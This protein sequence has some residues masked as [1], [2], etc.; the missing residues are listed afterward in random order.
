MRALRIATVVIL[1]SVFS[2]S[3]Q[4]ALACACGCGV[5]EVGGAGV[6]PSGQG[7]TAYLEFDYADQNRNWHGDSR[8]PAADND[9]KAVR[10]AFYTAGL[11]YMFNREWGMEVRV[12]YIYRAF[13][14]TDDATGDIVTNRHGAVGDIR[15]TGIYTGFSPDMSTGIMFGVKLPTGD[16]HFDGF[17]RDTA[18]GTGSTD[19]LLGFYHQDR[20]T[21]DNVYTWFAEAMWDQ[22]ILTHGDYRPGTEINASLGAYHKPLPLAGKLKITPVLQLI[23]TTRMRD[24][25]AEAMRDDSGYNRLAIA[26]AVELSYGNA[27]LY[28]DVEVPVWQQFNGNQLTAP[29]LF[30]VIASYEF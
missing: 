4:S 2:F 12:P 20:I 11:Q 7:G 10:N 14:T 30:K 5:F 15:L 6:M 13:T 21:K 3:S 28:G 24:T 16:Y 23:G 19:S 27:K 8:A 18:I 29:A 26:P 25:G 22:P 1:A 9:D 17:D